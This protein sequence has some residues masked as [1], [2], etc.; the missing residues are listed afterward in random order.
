MN[1]QFDQTREEVAESAWKAAIESTKEKRFACHADPDNPVSD[2]V[3]DLGQRWMCSHAEDLISRGLE[4]T[5]C[6]FWRKV[7]E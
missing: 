1:N 3:L 4:K 2:C 6:E 5:D 7:E